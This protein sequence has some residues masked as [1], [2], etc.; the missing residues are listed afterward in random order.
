VGPAGLR[1]A[2]TRAVL[3]V[4]PGKARQ[5]REEAAKRPWVERRAELSGNAALLGRE[6]PPAKVLADQLPDGTFRWTTPS[7]RQYTAEPTRYPI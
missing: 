7:G 2:I 1:S 4:A 5:R 3:Q 6:L